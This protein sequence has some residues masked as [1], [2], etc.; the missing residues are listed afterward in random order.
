M[1]YDSYHC[2]LLML[3]V[4]ELVT[5]RFVGGLLFLCSHFVVS[6]FVLFIIGM[7]TI[8]YVAI[9]LLLRMIYVLWLVLD[10][11]SCRGDFAAI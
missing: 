10:S 1:N 5:V 6:R 11:S 2:L 7:L 4:L 3:Y 8:G 9:T